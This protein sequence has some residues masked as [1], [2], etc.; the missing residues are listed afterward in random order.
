VVSGAKAIVELA[1]DIRSKKID[2]VV[3]LGGNPVY[4]APADAK[5]GEALAGATVVHLATHV[6]D[7]SKVATWHLNRA[8]FL[9]SWGDVR[10]EDGTASIVQPLIAPLWNGRTDA[11]VLDLILG[12]GRRAYDLVRATWQSTKLAGLD[13]DRTFRRMLHDGFVE[14]SAASAEVVNAVPADVAA[15][16]KKLAPAAEG[17]EV[18]FHVDPHA[19]DGRFA[20][21]GWLQELP[22]PMTKLTWGNAALLSPKTAQE[23]GVADGDMVTVTVNGASATLPAIIAPGQAHNSVAITIGYGRKNVGHVGTGVGVDTTALRA[24]T[25]FDVAAATV[26]K[27]GAHVEPSRTQEHFAMEGRP[28]V[29][30]GTL[31]EFVQDPDFAQK[32]AEKPSLFN[33]WKEHTY[34]GHAWGLNVDLNACVGCNACVT[35]CQ[36]ENNI[37]VVGSDGVSRSREMHWLRVDR[38]FE[39]DREEPSSH[40]QP[41]MCQQCENAPC[42]QVCPVGATTHSPEGLNDMAY[43]RCVGTRYCA[44]NCPFKVRKFNFFNYTNGLVEIDKMR[45][46][47]D[48]TVRSRGVMEK[49]T[50]CVQRINHAKI[51]A[52]K[53]GHDRVKDGVIQTA[54]QQ[55]CPTQAIVFGDLNDKSSHVAAR[56][57]NERSYRMLEELNV[58]P[59]VSYLAKVKNPNPALE[60]A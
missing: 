1:N 10:S 16:L 39:G 25:G 59:R 56:A 47:P 50:F 34:E 42:E 14:G 58:R 37:P 3:I 29:R 44:N 22:D 35:A 24:S 51:D 19:Y 40:A 54:C 17:W 13:F 26:A 30:E 41:V 7:T 11:E 53:E 36:A 5:L 60:G 55:A 49:C 48:V 12:H 20:N 6:D 33:L 15:A 28:L 2:T 52:K 27:A 45:M 32:K 21:N 4:N 8:H 9:E 31:K 46:N 18:T 38:Y 43:N 57:K 23:L